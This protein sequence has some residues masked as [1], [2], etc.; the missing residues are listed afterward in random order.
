MPTNITDDCYLPSG[1]TLHKQCINICLVELPAPPRTLSHLLE[2]ATFFLSGQKMTALTSAKFRS[3]S[4]PVYDSYAFQVCGTNASVK[5]GSTTVN[6]PSATANTRSK[7]RKFTSSFDSIKVNF[8]SSCVKCSQYIETKAALSFDQ[9]PQVK[10]IRNEHSDRR[11]LS[12]RT[13]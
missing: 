2:M 4:L 9:S 6:E 12:D 8:D 3:Q 13:K 1:K 5:R 10:K 11:R 7:Y